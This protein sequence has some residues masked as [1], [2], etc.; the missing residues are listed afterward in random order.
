MKT[1]SLGP[2]I[3]RG[4]TAEVYA[5]QQNQVIK[6]YFAWCPPQWAQQEIS[7]GR[8]IATLP[9]PTPKLIDVA[10]VDGRHGIIYERVVGPSMLKLATSK[11]W[12]LSRMA[13][14]LAELHTEMHKQPGTGLPS[15]RASLATTIQHVEDLPPGLKASVL[16][17]LEGLPDDTALCHFDFHPD[18]VL[19]TAN[20]PVILDWMTARQGHPLADVARTSIILKF[21]QVPGA[22]RLQ[23]AIVD[24]W[25][26]LFYRAYITRYLELHPG[27]SMAD[28]ET[29]MIPV[30]AGRL[31]E[32]IPG[33]QAPLLDFIQS[34]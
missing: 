25:R 9:V 27:V 4:R 21:S 20:G 24:L 14:Q 3:A 31:M 10:E 6:L 5:W 7:I 1:S 23:R 34:H 12:L 13:R 33:E 22:G 19:I 17:L 11:P 16:H 15:L 8:V 18:Q 26:H 30:A 32:K 28:I 29:W 2:L